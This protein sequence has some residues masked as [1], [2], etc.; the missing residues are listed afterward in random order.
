MIG[1]G[2]TLSLLQ[3]PPLLGHCPT[4][5]VDFMAPMETYSDKTKYLIYFIS[6]FFAYTIQ[7][8]Y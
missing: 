8:I 3:E 5:P 2:L 1:G 7:E 4:N 6:I